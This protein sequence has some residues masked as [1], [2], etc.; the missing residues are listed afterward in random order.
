MLGAIALAALAAPAQASPLT[1][2]LGFAAGYKVGNG[3]GLLGADVVVMPAARWA[4]DLQ[5]AKSAT[6][7]DFAPA[8]QYQ[9]DNAGD[10]VA[11]GYERTAY[12]V[13]GQVMGRNGLFANVGRQWQ[14]LPWL[15]V[16]AGIGYQYGFGARDTVADQTVDTPGY[17]GLNVELGVRYVFR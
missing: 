3:L 11:L 2:G 15:G 9:F 1:D 17:G 14:P 10:Y 8:L 7:V 13:L 5:L 4:L 12:E 6:G 16:I